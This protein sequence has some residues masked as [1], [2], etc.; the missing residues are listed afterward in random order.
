[1]IPIPTDTERDEA[2]RIVAETHEWLGNTDSD[3]SFYLSAKEKDDLINRIA[4]FAATTC[5]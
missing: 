3:S 4:N 1:M 5:Q 2:W